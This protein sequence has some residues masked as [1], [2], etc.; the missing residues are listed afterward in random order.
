MKVSKCQKFGE[1]LKITIMKIVVLVK[2]LKTEN[3]T[4]NALGFYIGR[5]LIP[6]K[7]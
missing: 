5:P 1:F 6:F 4:E 2:F 3:L 7:P